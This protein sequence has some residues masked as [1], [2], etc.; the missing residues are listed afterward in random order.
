MA[1]DFTPSNL[2]EFAASFSPFFITTFF[3]LYS[4]MMANMKGFIYLIG[5]CFAQLIGIGFK[6]ILGIKKNH[7]MNIVPKPGLF[8]NIFNPISES[9]KD[10]GPPSGHALFHMFTFGYI[11]LSIITNPNKPGIVFATA[12]LVMAFTNS[13]YRINRACETAQDV[14]LGGVLGILLG[15]VWWF[16]VFYLFPKGPTLVFFGAED[17]KKTCSLN[18]TKQKWRCTYNV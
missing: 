17:E 18:S 10:L 12:L 16:I 11:V 2:L 9:T 4:A 8:C 7:G 3:I 14:L 13:A 1:I 5:A 15:F 6:M